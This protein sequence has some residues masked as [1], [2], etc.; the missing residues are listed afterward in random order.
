MADIY[1]GEDLKLKRKVAV[2]ILSRNYAGDRNF[3][4]RFKSEAQVLAKLKHPNIVDIYDWGKFDDSYFI[5]MEYIDGVSL[6]ELIDRKGALDPKVSTHLVIQICEALLF[7]HN[8][9]LIHRDVKP[10]NILITSEK[11][12]KVTD[13][14][15]AKSLNTDITKTLN[16]EG[17]AQYISPEQARGSVLDNRTDIYSLGVVFYEMLTGD[18]PFRGDTSVDISLKQVSEKPA[19]LSSLIVGIPLKLEKIVMTCLEKDPGRR[20]E[21]IESLKRDLNNYLEGKPVLLGRS[22][23]DH[24]RINIFARWISKN[25]V[26]TIAIAAAII[27]FALFLTYSILFYEKDPVVVEEVKIPPIHDMHIDSARQTL[28]FFNLE[29]EVIEEVYNDTVP[30]N[31]VI[32]QDPGPNGIVTP[33]RTVEVIVSMGSKNSGI[34]IPNMIGLDIQEALKILESMGLE[35]DTIS[36]EYSEEFGKDHIIK[37]TPAYDEMAN[38][39]D[40]VDLTISM[41][42]QTV[43]IPNI[44]GLDLVY[45]SNHLESLGVN[46][47]TSKIPLT[48][49]ISQPGLVVSVIPQPGTSIIAGSTVELKIS[50]SELLNEVPDITGLDLEQAKEKLG[51]LGI[52]IEI[53]YI[54]TDYSVQQGEVLDQLPLPGN[55]ISL[56]SSV[57]LF[58]GK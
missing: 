14:G 54:D 42:S 5:I 3:V 6:K 25:S 46:V 45:A 1:L 26:K 13:F 8:N 7:A 23:K 47:I 34:S 50:T 57:V 20:Y 44:I 38:K 37:Q 40:T 24:K 10:Q 19:K 48:E 49:D 32:E 36:E 21:N 52:G 4:A 39:E 18:T 29:M 17:T 30:E 15:I 16:I 2:K 22:R 31:Y 28:S 58:I 56:N 33:D 51:T 11:I 43:I 35:T 55:Y 9:N 53:I 12:I 27:F 41:G